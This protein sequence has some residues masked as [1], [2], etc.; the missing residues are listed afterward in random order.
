[1]VPA[2]HMFPECSLNV[3]WKFTEYWRWLHLGRYCLQ[4][5]SSLNVHWM[6]TK[7][8]LNVHWMFTECLLNVGDDFPWEDGACDPQVHWMFTKCS[9]NVHW[10]FTERWWWLPL[11]RW[12]LQSTSSLNVHWMFTKCSLNVHRMFTECSLNVGDDTSYLRLAGGRW[13]SWDHISIIIVS[14]VHS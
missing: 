10:M 8:S 12:C 5:T 11:G 3:H 9:L 14:L 13:L 1:M 7:C 6:F 4:S 2:I